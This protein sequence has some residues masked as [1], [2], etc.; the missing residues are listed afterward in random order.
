MNTD[1]EL[2]RRFV[3][4]RSEAAFTD[5]VQRYLPMVRAT[6]LRR[7]GGDAHAADDVAQ[8]V[9]VAL[10]RKAPSLRTHATLAGWLHLSTHHAT[11]SWVRGEQRRKHREATADSMQ[12]NDSTADLS[13][14][15]AR[16][17]PLLDDALVTLKPEEREA[18]VLRFFSGRSF[19]EIGD[20]L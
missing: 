8:Q 10:A 15:T 9:F 4:D 3:E 14:D 19:A 20:A 17:R 11:A 1:S 7:V 16:L 18:I 5:L 13:A 2:L 12:R 6:A